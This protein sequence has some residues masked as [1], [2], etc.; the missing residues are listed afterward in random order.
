MTIQP[1]DILRCVCRQLGARKLSEFRTALNNMVT[2][3]LS[4]QQVTE[5]YSGP[6]SLVAIA[7]AYGLDGPGSE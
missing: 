2:Q 1:R 3:K 4:L 5:R 6:G 7:A